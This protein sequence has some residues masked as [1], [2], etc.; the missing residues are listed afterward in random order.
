MSL[1]EACRN[2]IVSFG[3]C[4]YSKRLLSLSVKLKLTFWT[5]SFFSVGL[6]IKPNITVRLKK[7][8]WCHIWQ[9]LE[10]WLWGAQREEQCFIFSRTILQGKGQLSQQ[11][12]HYRCH[13]FKSCSSVSSHSNKKP[14]GYCPSPL[15]SL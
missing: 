1:S 10:G 13:S 3:Q 14:K 15:L 9:G 6:Q 4:R 12:P 11:K 8:H 7:A 2:E 5:G